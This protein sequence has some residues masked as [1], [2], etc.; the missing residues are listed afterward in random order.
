M[1]SVHTKNSLA[2]R[3][4]IAKIDRFFFACAPRAPEDTGRRGDVQIGPVGY[5]RSTLHTI[6]SGMITEKGEANPAD[7]ADTPTTCNCD[8]RTTEVTGTNNLQLWFLG[9]G[10]EM[11]HYCEAH[12]RSREMEE[13]LQAASNRLIE[14]IEELLGTTPVHPSYWY[15]IENTKHD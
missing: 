9:D 4:I 15:N 11:V 13:A 2:I 1:K 5:A 10:S 14:M 8:D 7:K 6:D 3:K 12:Q